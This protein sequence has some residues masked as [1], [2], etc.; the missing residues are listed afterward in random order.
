M[1]ACLHGVGRSTSSVQLL[2]SCA[3]KQP[4]DLYFRNHDRCKTTRGTAAN[5]CQSCNDWLR[6]VFD[7]AVFESRCLE[8]L[9]A[10]PSLHCNVQWHAKLP[11]WLALTCALLDAVRGGR[12]PVSMRAASLGSD[13]RCCENAEAPGRQ[14]SAALLFGYAPPVHQRYQAETVYSTRSTSASA[15]LGQ[16]RR[17]ATAHVSGNEH[18]ACSRLSTRAGRHLKKTGTQCGQAAPS[19]P[20]VGD[21]LAAARCSA[22]AADRCQSHHKSPPYCNRGDAKTSSARRWRSCAVYW[23]THFL[24]V[25]PEDRVARSCHGESLLKLSVKATRHYFSSTLAAHPGPRRILPPFLSVNSDEKSRSL[26]PALLGSHCMWACRGPLDAARSLR[27]V[28][29]A[30]LHLPRPVMGS[31]N[32]S[33]RRDVCSASA[34]HRC[35]LFTHVSHACGCTRVYTAMCPLQA[36]KLKHADSTLCSKTPL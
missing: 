19:I 23:R 6:T 28:T 10:K 33:C 30:T 4:S 24:A 32:S 7:C 8:Q 20:C 15:E 9:I 29:A 5:T 25:F 2:V 1:N 26:V 3:G 22:S 27:D 18:W 21:S 17:C 16:M 11:A 35:Q 13:H 12:M 36:P 31:V 34:E 14:L